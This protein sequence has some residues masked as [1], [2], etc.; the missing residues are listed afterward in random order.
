VPASL[1]G[2]HTLEITM[3]GK[4]PATTTHVVENRFAPATPHAALTGNALTWGA[5]KGAVR[6]VVYRNGEAVARTTRTTSP[7][8]PRDGL[9]E[10]QVLAVNAVGDQSFLSEPVRV[11]ADGAE[12]LVK[13]AGD[14]LER[15]YAGFSGG[16]YLRLT[17]ERNVTVA[18]PVQVARA[19]SYAIDF[20]YANGNG[21]VNTEDKVAVRTVI[22]DGDTTGV[23][24][25]PQRGVNRWTE[26][27]WSNPLHVT[28]APGAHTVT[29]AYTRYDANMNRRENTALLDALRLTRLASRR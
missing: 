18:I 17:R 29:V 10:Y 1:S 5:V 23:V 25:L 20:R 26:W 16:G 24:V 14:S 9:D 21:P 8:R 13:P 28:L 19:G 4:W 2:A 6:Y 3:N 12:Q 7:V 27:G 22:V 11:V 15:E